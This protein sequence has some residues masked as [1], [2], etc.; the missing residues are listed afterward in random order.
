MGMRKAKIGILTGGGD[1]PGLNAVIKAAV[2]RGNDFGFK[3]YGIYDGWKGLLEDGPGECMPLDYTVVRTWD[4]DGG[5]NIGSSRTNPFACKTESGEVVDRSDEVPRMMKKMGLDAIIACGGEDTLGV[6]H[7]LAKKGV[8]V[9]G[10]P[11][12]ID[13]DLSGTD[14]TIGFDTA[15]RT[16]TMLIENARTPAGSHHWVQVLEVMGRHAG[17]LAFWSGVAGGAYII[18]IPEVPFELDRVFELIDK[19]LSKGTKDRRYPSYAVVV[20]A[21]GATEKGGDIV[22]LDDRTDAFGH[23]QLGGIGSVLSHAIRTRTKWDARSANLGHVQRGGSPSPTDRIMATLFGTAAIDA[24]A[25]EQFG[26]MVSAR[27]I[28]PACD[29]NLVDLEEGVGRLHL[30]NAARYYDPERYNIRRD[31]KYWW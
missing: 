19:R 17:H 2:Y 12:T 21:E 28:A 1:A 16:C 7:K 4:R 30:F 11:K 26:K 6:A 15:L 14:Y 22:T 27:G 9:V 8:P 18:L 13:K 10:V 24:L 23:K 20:V 3:L 29:I 25:D 31:L 5:T